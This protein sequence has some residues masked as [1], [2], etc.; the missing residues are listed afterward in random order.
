MNTRSQKLHSIQHKTI[1]DMVHT[2][3]DWQLDIWEDIIYSEKKSRGRVLEEKEA[4]CGIDG[5]EYSK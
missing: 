1:K 5:G 2:A 4:D 3:K